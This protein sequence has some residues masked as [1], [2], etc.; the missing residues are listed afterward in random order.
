MMELNDGAHRASPA[1]P[2]VLK[3]VGMYG[4]QTVLR[5][6]NLHL[7][8]LAEVNVSLDQARAR[9]IHMSRLYSVLDRF[10]TEQALSLHAMPM[11]LKQIKDSQDGLSQRAEL[12]LQFDLPLRR[13]ALKSDA[14]GW[15]H[16]PIQLRAVLE[17]DCHLE[18]GFKLHYSSTCPCSFNLARQSVQRN[19]AH[20]FGERAAFDAA[21]VHAW[22]GQTGSINATPHAQRSEM[23][24]LL[25]LAPSLSSDADADGAQL[26]ALLFAL[27]D[28]IE[29]RLQ[30]PVQTAVK[31]AD[32]QAFAELNGQNPMFVEDAVRNVAAWLD[33]Y[34]HFVD[35]R[36]HTKH[37][38]S[39]HA[40]DAQA[41][42]SKGI[43]GGY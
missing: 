40:H 24:V 27:I 30:T 19:F 16:Y 2:K 13:A 3:S 8:A 39:L 17:Q 41:T 21:E 28:A 38:E 32:E 4:V 22:L 26:Y 6:K 14:S 37:L 20:H 1:H 7:S 34:A 9:G 18:L 33:G 42:A 10:L 25:K 36:V 43:A 12:A 11:L 35:F 29:K 23:E 15:R 5:L 31:R